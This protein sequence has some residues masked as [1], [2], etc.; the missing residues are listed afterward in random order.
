MLQYWKLGYFL[1][2]LK[3]TQEVMMRIQTKA[4][5]D[6]KEELAIKNDKGI[7]TFLDLPNIEGNREVTLERFF[8]NE[9]VIYNCQ[10][11]EN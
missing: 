8:Q 5:A 11:L 3:I 2:T 10:W 7:H 4:V 6:E 9:N 1:D